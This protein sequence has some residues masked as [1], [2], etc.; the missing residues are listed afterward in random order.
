MQLRNDELL[1]DAP[2]SE[3][4]A[5]GR[6]LRVLVVHNAYQLRGGEDSVAD[7]EIELLRAHGHAVETYWRSNDEIA[8]IGRA[9]AA[10]QTLWSSKTVKDI[11]ALI[12]RFKPDVIHAH[13]TTPLISPSLYWVASRMKV[14]VV[15]TLHNFRL[16]CPQA[17]LLRDNKVCEDC[18]GKIPWRGVVRACYRGSVLQS[19]VMAAMTSGHRALGTWQN[20]VS[21]YIAL[22]EFAKNKYIQGGLPADRI[23]VKPNFVSVAAQPPVS[24]SGFLF[25][26]RLSHEKGIQVLMDAMKLVPEGVRLRVVGSGPLEAQVRGVSG[27][28]LVGPLGSEAVYRE[29]RSAQALILPSICFENFPR[30]IV[31]AF[32][33]GLPVLASDLG[34]LKGIVAPERTGLLFEAGDAAA[35]AASLHWAMAHPEDL[36]SM[37]IAA[38][39]EY[40]SKLTP[41]INYTKLIGIYQDA[42]GAV[43]SLN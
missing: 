22:N 8:S 33:C 25:V 20:K 32:A 10:I 43:A 35:L 4:P 14:P 34:P 40:E 30:T 13:N 11:E 23:S 16:L 18:V 28:E 42:I 17:L 15:Q 21:R 37:G 29:M 1:P 27:V 6:R 7:S 41:D 9:Q 19:G 26:G 24:R 36:A 5:I 31:E 39:E 12:I 3:K 2:V 38:R